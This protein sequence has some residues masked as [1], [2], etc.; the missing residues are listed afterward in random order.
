[1]KAKRSSAHWSA[2]WI[3][4]LAVAS[5]LSLGQAQTLPL[6]YPFDHGSPSWTSLWWGPAS[7]VKW[8]SS[9]DANTNFSSG[10][11]RC[12][13]G[14]NGTDNGCWGC[15]E[16]G[17]TWD[18]NINIDNTQ[19]QVGS[20]GCDIRVDPST[21]LTKDGDYGWWHIQVLSKET[22]TLT[23]LGNVNLPASATNWTHI[24]LPV[25]PNT[26]PHFFGYA[27][28]IWGGNYTNS[29]AF[30][31]DNF[32]VAPPAPPAQVSI[33]D[34]LYISGNFQFTIT[35]MVIGTPYAIQTSTDLVNWNYLSDFTAGDTS[36]IIGDTPAPGTDH[37]YYRVVQP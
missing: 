15:A 1:M 21:P 4:G 36:V 26:P 28:T 31:V 25:S 12:E 18:Q 32:V 19:G 24:S 34:P 10:S 17:W 29:L 37:L 8:D 16:D 22:W 11:V 23:D 2:L 13:A 6:T 14:M 35:N 9:L 30:N 27:L 20:I 33:V 5:N 7:T 3:A